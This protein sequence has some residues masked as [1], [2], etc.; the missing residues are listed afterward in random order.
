M[1]DPR[2]LLI[3]FLAA[4]LV[5]SAAPAPFQHPTAAATRLVPIE[6]EPDAVVSNGRAAG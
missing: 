5:F 2:L 4:F 6:V 3:A 1:L